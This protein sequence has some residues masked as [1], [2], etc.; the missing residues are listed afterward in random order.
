MLRRLLRK[1][2]Q[3]LFLNKLLSKTSNLMARKRGLPVVIGLVL[4]VVA[5]ALDII[6]L[7]Q[8]S[9]VIEIITVITH[10]LGVLI[11]IIGLMLATPLGK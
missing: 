4:L 10:N 1:I 2:D 5:F 8:D 3:S 9:H 11:A 7:S 6:N